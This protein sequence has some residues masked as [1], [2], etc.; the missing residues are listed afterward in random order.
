MTEQNAFVVVS[1]LRLRQQVGGDKGGVRAFIGDNGDFRRPGQHVYADLAVDQAF[2]RV[3]IGIAGADNDIT[4]GNGFRAVGHCR[5][6]LRPADFENLAFTD[7]LAF[8]PVNQ[9]L[10]E[11]RQFSLI[12]TRRTDYKLPDSGNAGRLKRH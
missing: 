1:M 8:Q 6:C 9:G 3:D 11:W 12:V 4:F 10:N 5:N 2:G 7:A